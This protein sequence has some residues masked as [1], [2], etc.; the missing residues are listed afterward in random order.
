MR[1]KSM[2]Q[3]YLLT[4]VADL[5]LPFHN[6]L[7]CICEVKM[8]AP[9]F[10]SPTFWIFLTTLIIQI[11]C[12]TE[13]ILVHQSPLHV[14]VNGN[15]EIF[16]NYTYEKKVEKFNVW[17]L[18]GVPKREAVCSFKCSSACIIQ[19]DTTG[20]SC[21]VTRKEK[22]VVFQLQNLSTGQ[23]DI[24]VCKIEVTYPPP[25]VDNESNN[26]TFI[27]VT[28]VLEAPKC[29]CPPGGS[30]YTWMTGT[31]GGLVLYGIAITA[32]FCY[33]WVKSKKRKIVRNDYFNMTPWQVNGER[34]KY[35]TSGPVRN[36]TA[37]R[38]WEP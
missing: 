22:G 9:P 18:K 38:S 25:Y 14:V 37:Y 34:K 3:W 26:G 30:E 2:R 36:Y 12:I 7:L 10:H 28:G 29:Q 20:F 33:C 4:Q 35:Q 16:C 8:S 31:I 6:L 5:L 19:N 15:A 24:Y 23:T 13:A 17:L 11:A 1:T 21:H 32:A 27:N